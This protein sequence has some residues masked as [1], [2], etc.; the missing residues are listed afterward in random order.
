M[1]IYRTPSAAL[2][3]AAKKGDAYSQD[4]VKIVS[5]PGKKGKEGY[6]PLLKKDCKGI[7][8]DS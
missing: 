2:R 8:E 3:A 1:K 5:I 6:I 4:T 7:F